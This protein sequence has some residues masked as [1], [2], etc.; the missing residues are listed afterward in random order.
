[1]QRRDLLQLL[2]TAAVFTGG[3]TVT[4]NQSIL[5]FEEDDCFLPECIHPTYG[6]I[7]MSPD[8]VE[9][10]PE[11]LQPAH[12]VEL[13]TELPEG[14]DNEETADDEAGGMTPVPEFYFEPTGLSIEPGDVVQFTLAAPEHTVTAYHPDLGRQR[15]VPEGVPPL[16]SPVLADATFWLYRFD[17]PGVYDLLCAPHE[18]F[19]MVMRVVVGEPEEDFGEAEPPDRRGPELTAD[20][21][22]NDEALAPDNIDSEGEVGWGELADDSK[23]VLVNFEEPTEQPE[24]EEDDDEEEY[25]YVDEVDEQVTLEYGE[26]AELSN[27]VTFTLH[28]IEIYE[29]LGDEEPEDRDAFV[30]VHAEAENTSDEERTLPGAT[31]PIEI[32]FGDVQDGPVFNHGALREGGYEQLEGGDVQPGVRREG[33]IL[34]EVDDGYGED[35][36]DILWQDSIFVPDDGE[37]DVVW[38]ATP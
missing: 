9:E 25:E 28:G 14:P 12:E 33:V 4:A 8:D 21:V 2:G 10:L 32:L 17:E 16:S 35:E 13:V 29:S 34:Y 30:V 22:L 7:G 36:I 1:M 20:L 15:R 18:A 6:Y 38:T 23:R 37:V 5:Q 24:D 27:G 3:S 26:T 19:G 11:D 31:Y